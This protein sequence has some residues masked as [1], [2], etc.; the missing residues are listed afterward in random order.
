M[1]AVETLT[2]STPLP[3]GISLTQLYIKVQIYLMPINLIT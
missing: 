2:F 3:S 1:A